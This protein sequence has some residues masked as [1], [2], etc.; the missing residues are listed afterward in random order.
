MTHVVNIDALRPLPVGEVVEV[1]AATPKIALRDLRLFDLLLAGER[2]AALRHG[3]YL[4]FDGKGHCVYVGMC[5]SSH[6]AHR[7]GGHFGMSPRYGMNT[8]LRRAI[9]DIGLDQG[10][11][12]GYVEGVERIGDYRLL[13]VDAN[14]T[15]KK[16]IRA[17]ER[18]LHIAMRPRL[19]FPRGLPA[20]YGAMDDAT[21]FP[22]AI[23][24]C[25]GP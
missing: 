13:L 4:F 3:V 10:S 1:L 21:R 12:G 6:F 23:A 14:G 9:K 25:G 7:I 24:L 22:D 17:L 11:Y 15:G 19:N 2:T 8:F 16:F 18:L 5:S 20:T